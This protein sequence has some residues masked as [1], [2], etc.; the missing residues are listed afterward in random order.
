MQL[1]FHTCAESVKIAPCDTVN[2]VLK[3]KKKKYNF[4]QILKKCCAYD[5]CARSVSNYC[6]QKVPSTVH[7]TIW[8][9]QKF[10][11]LTEYYVV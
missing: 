1:D 6:I 8:K 9:Q 11:S 2:P 5:K 7:L 4:R 3:L 10:I